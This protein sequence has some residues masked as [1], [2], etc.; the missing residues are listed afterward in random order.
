MAESSGVDA[1]VLLRQAHDVGLGQ[2]NELSDLI[3]TPGWQTTSEALQTLDDISRFL[4]GELRLHFRHEEEALFPALE[5]VLGRRGMIMMMLAEHRSLWRAA[6]VLHE[7]SVELKTGQHRDKTDWNTGLVAAR[8]VWLLRSHIGKENT[9]LL[10]LAERTLSAQ[11][12]QELA[13][14]MASIH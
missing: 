3:G 13:T 10:P 2:L 9:M 4:E 14:R 12:L 1:M 7:K 8:I 6:D 5:K 11:T